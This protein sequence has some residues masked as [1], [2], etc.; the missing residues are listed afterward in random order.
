MRAP[1]PVAGIP[2]AS[3]LAVAR[4]VEHFLAVLGRIPGRP[5]CFRKAPLATPWAGL[6]KDMVRYLAGPRRSIGRSLP[7]AAEAGVAINE[8]ATGA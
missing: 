1:S 8:L 6:V 5:G 7:L 3:F 4:L 2:V